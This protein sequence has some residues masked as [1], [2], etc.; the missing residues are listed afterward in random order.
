MFK[1]V[2]VEDSVRVP[3]E[4]FEKELED[5][6][7][8][9]IQ[10]S[11]EGVFSQELGIVLNLESVEEVG[12]GRV[13]PEDGGVYYPVKFKLLIFM[14]EEHEVTLGEIVDITEFGAFVR[15]GPVDA[16]THISQIMNDYVSY[17]KKNSVLVGR[18]K[19]NVLKEGDLIRA[20]IISISFTKDNRVGLTM[21]QPGLGALKW[22]IDKDKK[23]SKS[24]AA[25]QPKK[26][27]SAEKPKEEPEKEEK[28]PEKE[29]DK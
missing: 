9:S 26:P 16:M 10:E 29:G 13:V 4:K 22:M 20:R 28:T 15:I 19:K 11:F 18:D 8:E 24:Q 27:D 23:V 17:D 14:P 6:I 3:P 12:E 1:I 21:R 5:S 7:G 2:E 25:G